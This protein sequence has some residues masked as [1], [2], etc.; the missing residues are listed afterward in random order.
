MPK[1]DEI[2]SLTGLLSIRAFREKASDLQ[3]NLDLENRQIAVVFLDM[4]DFKGLNER[5]GFEE[6]DKTL[7]RFAD[8]MKEAFHNRLI[9]R[10]GSDHFAA[11][12]YADE[13]SY[14]VSRLRHLMDDDSDLSMMHFRS[15]VCVLTDPSFDS[16]I[17][18]DRAKIAADS[19]RGEND[20][21]RYYD[22]ELD[23]IIRRQRYISEN[24]DIAIQNEYIR[25]YYQPVISSITGNLVGMEALARWDDPNYGFLSP[26]VFIPTLEEK[27]L[28]HKLD[29]CVLERVC[30]DLK[31]W[32]DNGIPVVPVSFNL[33]RL[34]F[35]L[36]DAIGIIEK[37]VR[38]YKIQ[39]SLLH[40][41]ITESTLGTNEDYISNIIDR[42]HSG[43][44]E[45][46]MDDFGSGYS[47]L[48]V[49]KDYDFDLIKIDMKFL[50]EFNNRSKEI[51][52]S[53]VSM[54]KNLG[55]HVLAEG[56]ETEDHVNFLRE[57][58]CEKLQGFYYS[59][60]V[61][62]TGETML[63][64]KKKWGIEPSSLRQYYKKIGI[65]PI[66]SI[67]RN[68]FMAPAARQKVGRKNIVPVAII[69]Y[70]DN[71][72]HTTFSNSVFREGIGQYGIS[73]ENDF[74]DYLSSKSTPFSKNFSRK[75]SEISDPEAE[76]D[77][78]QIDFRSNGKIGLI[79]VRKVSS[80]AGRYAFLLDIV[81]L[82][83]SREY[84]KLKDLGNISTSLYSVFDFIFLIDYEHGC[85]EKLFEKDS[86]NGISDGRLPLKDAAYVF[87]ERYIH[88]DDRA[89]YM[90]DFAKDRFMNDILKS[91]NGYS[92][93]YYRT[94]NNED[95]FSWAE[96]L[97]F[98]TDLTVQSFAL[99]VRY[100][101]E[102]EAYLIDRYMSNAEVK[103]DAIT[104]KNMEI[105][106]SELWDTIM[107]DRRFGI[108]WKDADRRFLGANRVFLD[109][110]GLLSQNDIIGKNDEDMRWHID[111]EPF[112][113]DE[114][115]VLKYGRSTRM[116]LGKCIANG[117]NRDIAATKRPVYRDGRVVGLLGYFVDVTEDEEEKAILS[118]QR[119]H[120]RLTGLLNRNGLK[121]DI[122]DLVD[123]YSV[124][125]TDFALFYVDIRDFRKFN[126]NYG[127]EV[128]D[129]VL[130]LFAQRLKE[131]VGRESLIGRYAGD[132]FIICSQIKSEDDINRIHDGIEKS[133]SKIIDIDGI[134]C[135]IYVSQGYALYSETNNIVKMTS[136][137]FEKAVNG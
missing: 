61:P 15:G 53:V 137:A 95:G 129:M 44:F 88:P 111:P 10:F 76:N 115:T 21:V 26:G 52:R 33:S 118:E 35:E 29:M 62:V 19:I 128:G 24:I 64:F 89:S 101:G 55:V 131:S 104:D 1:F 97:I 38:K 92:L 32:E 100:L 79:N 17:A 126:E 119:F 105:T 124:N 75:I 83:G 39:T 72:Y 103:N 63:E 40:I 98:K 122:V 125:G 12:L 20:K 45:V 42:A 34:D 7:I 84:R 16:V 113:K 54:A 130:R 51:I 36:C 70:Y 117:S 71:K 9:S 60:P 43:G 80:T 58:G 86:T 56:V 13:V 96:F 110:Y 132:Q 11:I 87:S 5:R 81:N 67:T 8:L 134:P 112:K 59:R 66:N 68:D 69:E 120:D 65:L 82:S 127:T 135:T 74:A 94:L 4:V 30:R 93:H 85:Y 3:H 107:T 47:S 50:S 116:I 41:E 121:H 27:H 14:S 90:R 46:W 106:K 73:D 2:D 114:E 133:A 109:Y 57:I 48:N 22:D 18:C 23:L 108:F 28:I 77:T 91:E 78:F 25:V 31:T 49:L 6:G 99:C 136:V 102:R 37:T 123:A